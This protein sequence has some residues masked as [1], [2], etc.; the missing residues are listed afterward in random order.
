[1]KVRALVDIPGTD[2]RSGEFFEATDVVAKG[3]VVSG[4]ADDKAKETDVY[5]DGNIP[6]AKAHP[7]T[8]KKTEAADAAKK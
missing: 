5:P 3:L 8:A 2:I 4:D 1:M 7:S 6:P